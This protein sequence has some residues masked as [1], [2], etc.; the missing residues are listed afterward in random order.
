MFSVLGVF[1]A[2]GVGF[3]A[4]TAFGFAGLFISIPMA[5]LLGWG[6]AALDAN[7]RDNRRY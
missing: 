7:I 1:L 4:G 6:G 2:T 3:L 5:I